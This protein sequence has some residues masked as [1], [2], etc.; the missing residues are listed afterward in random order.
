MAGY[1]FDS[2]SPIVDGLDAIFPS[3]RDHHVKVYRA[4][5]N[6]YGSVEGWHRRRAERANVHRLMELRARADQGTADF[7]QRIAR[8]HQAWREE[9]S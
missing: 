4:I 1:L 8:S 2:A 7:L 3:Q 5:M 6:A 9:R